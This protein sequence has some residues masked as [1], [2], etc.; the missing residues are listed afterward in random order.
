MA[1][2]PELFDIVPGLPEGFRYETELI[3]RGLER[4]LVDQFRLLP[5]EPFRFHGYA[6]NRRV[7]SYGFRYDFEGA[8]PQ[9][10]ESVPGFLHPLRTAAAELAD[11][12]EHELVH[13]LVTEYGPGAGI[14]WHRD[15]AA[16]GDV[17]GIS[18]CSPC[19]FRMRRRGSRAWERATITAEPRSGYLLSGPART[20]WEHSIPALGNLRY[21]VTFRTLR[22]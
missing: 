1:A 2:H 11:I 22:K 6:G 19:R 14:G 17:V 4:V 15:K 7:V 9:K 5:F 21:S 16:Y 8:G 10:A 18:L 12:P 20:E 13:V 3:S